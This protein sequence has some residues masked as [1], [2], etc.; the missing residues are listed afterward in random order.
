M[1]LFSYFVSLK[2]GL[3]RNANTN[4]A[5]KNDAYVHVGK[6]VDCS[7]FAEAANRPYKNVLCANSLW[8]TDSRRIAFGCSPNVR[9][10]AEYCLPHL[11]NTST[12]NIRIIFACRIRVLFAFRCKRS[13][14]W[15]VDACHSNLH[16]QSCSP[17]WV[18]V[19][20]ALVQVIGRLMYNRAIARLVSLFASIITSPYN[21]LDRNVRIHPPSVAWLKK[22]ANVVCSVLSSCTPYVRIHTVTL[23]LPCSSNAGLTKVVRLIICNYSPIHL[24]FRYLIYLLHSMPFRFHIQDFK[25][26]RSCFRSFSVFLMFEGQIKIPA[27]CSHFSQ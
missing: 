8:C 26:L 10:T 27:W 20:P 24:V 3:H 23:A 17:V 18:K 6:F 21:W 4:A 19:A 15:K 14:K 13:L 9:H 22:T 25:Y 1:L 5:C 2:A 12:S 16:H 11:R 7:A